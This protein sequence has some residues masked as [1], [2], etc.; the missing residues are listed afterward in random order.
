[1]KYTFDDLIYLF[2]KSNLSLIKTIPL[3]IK[4]KPDKLFGTEFTLPDNDTRKSLELQAKLSYLNGEHRQLR[5]DGSKIYVLYTKSIPEN[6][7]VTAPDKIGLMPVVPIIHTVD[8]NTGKQTYYEL[9]PKFDFT[10][11]YLHNGHVYLVSNRFLTETPHLYKIK[12]N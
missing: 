5:V 9:P 3:S 1:V 12:L 7:L 4:V 6:R 11:F 10:N 8:L 2:D